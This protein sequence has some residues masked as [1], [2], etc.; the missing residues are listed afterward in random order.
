[1][2]LAVIVIMIMIMLGR[3]G[4]VVCLVIVAGVGVNDQMTVLM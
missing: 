4:G 3:N 1:M 2:T